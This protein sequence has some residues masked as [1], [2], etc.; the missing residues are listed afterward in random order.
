MVDVEAQLDQVKNV[1]VCGVSSGGSCRHDRL[2]DTKG[3]D[4][5]LLR[6]GVLD[7]LGF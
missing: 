5:L 7:P 4:V 6:G 2:D 3:G 1:A